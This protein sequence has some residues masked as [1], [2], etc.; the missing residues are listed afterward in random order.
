MQYLIRN[1]VV[2]K[3]SKKN[4]IQK[5]SKELMLLLLTGNPTDGSTTLLKSNVVAAGI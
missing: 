2:M 1:G 5:E 3:R 4:K